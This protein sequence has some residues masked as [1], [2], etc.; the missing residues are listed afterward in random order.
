MFCFIVALC[1][2]VHD[3]TTIFHISYVITVSANCSFTGS[4]TGIT[5]NSEKISRCC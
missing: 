4:F 5:H 3:V 1:D 2:L